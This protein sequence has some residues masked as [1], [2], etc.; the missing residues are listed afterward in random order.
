MHRSRDE[1]A[2]VVRV[3]SQKMKP[4]HPALSTTFLQTLALDAVEKVCI[5]SELPHFELTMDMVDI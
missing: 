5:E 3:R 4:L 1:S 2:S